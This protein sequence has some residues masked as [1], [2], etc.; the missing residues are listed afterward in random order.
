LYLVPCLRRIDRREKLDEPRLAF[1][2]AL[3]PLVR[4]RLVD[5]RVAQRNR[6]IVAHRDRGDDL[7]LQFRR[8][9]A[10]GQLAPALAPRRRPVIAKIRHPCPPPLLAGV[11]VAFFAPS[12]RRVH[13]RW[14]GTPYADKAFAGRAAAM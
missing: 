14:A 2:R 6:R 10:L 12:L 5:A 13:R 1:F 4:R 9:P 11:K 7:L 8:R 3:A